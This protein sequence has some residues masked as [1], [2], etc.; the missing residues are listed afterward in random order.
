MNLS[1]MMNVCCFDLEKRIVE[2]TTDER[3]QREVC[4]ECGRVIFDTSA[5]K[6]KTAN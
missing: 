5:E 4:S 2:S 1:P 3:I 6:E